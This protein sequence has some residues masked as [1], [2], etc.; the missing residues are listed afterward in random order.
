MKL[1]KTLIAALALTNCLGCA[2]AKASATELT[3]CYE[4][5]DQQQARSAELQSIVNADQ[6][7]RE[8][9]YDKIDWSKVLPRDLERR[10]RVGEIF[11][12][13]CFKTAQ[14]FAA[15]A[16]VYQHGEAPDH[17]YQAFI[18]AKKAV[19]LGAG[20]EQK[21]LTAAGLDRYLVRIGQKELFAT[22]YS[23]D[24]GSTCWC[25]EP[26]EAS[27][28]ETK[29]VEYT[30]LNLSQALAR[31]NSMNTGQTSCIEVQYCQHPLKSSPA[32]TVPGFW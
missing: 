5:P 22:Q 28:P 31:L 10:A 9:P 19:D 7:D 2:H 17:F 27:F 11:A 29:R 21:W 15:A 1:L 16:L 12:E 8:L 14:D 32:G 20:Q 4:H 6:A 30:K 25:L 18:W 3:S 23:R 26:V 13:G 24:A